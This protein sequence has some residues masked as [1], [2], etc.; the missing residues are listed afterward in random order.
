MPTADYGTW[1][2]PISVD[3]LVSA[4]VG[5]SGVRIDGDHLY[6]L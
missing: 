4:V 1:A 2:S 3:A 5:L 6:W